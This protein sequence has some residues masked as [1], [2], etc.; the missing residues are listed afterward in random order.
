[1]PGTDETRSAFF[2][3]SFAPEDMRMARRIMYHLTTHGVRLWHDTGI[4]PAPAWETDTAK[5]IQ[6]CEAVIV[7]LSEAYVR[8]EACRAELSHAQALGKDC[9]LV[10]LDDVEL[11]VEPE[12]WHSAVDAIAAFFHETE[13]EFLRE[14]LR[15]EMIQQTLPSMPEPSMFPPIGIMPDDPLLPYGMPGIVHDDWIE[16]AECLTLGGTE[17]TDVTR[18]NGFHGY[19]SHIFR[20]TAKELSDQPIL[21]KQYSEQYA[22][23]LAVFADSELQQALMDLRHDNLSRIYRIVGEEKRHCLVME[24]IEGQTLAVVLRNEQLTA[25]GVF[26]YMKDILLGLEA[27]HTQKRPILYLDVSTLNVVIDGEKACMI[28][29]SEANFSGRP[30]PD[31]ARTHLT[32]WSPERLN[33]EIVDC[34]S[35]IY[36]SG[37]LLRQMAENTDWDADDA[38][39]AVLRCKQW[40]RRIIERATQPDRED[41]YQ[42]VQEMLAHVDEALKLLD[43]Q[44]PLRTPKARPGIDF[45]WPAGEFG[46]GTPFVPD[47]GPVG[48][49]GHLP[50]MEEDEDK[51]E[52]EDD[53]AFILRT[54]LEL[55]DKCET[56]EELRE[57]VRIILGDA[58][59]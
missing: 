23:E 26:R 13:E 9:V 30:Y 4:E 51:D 44:G 3:V 25:R 38:P 27:L 14:L 54:I 33:G 16:P 2:Y 1:M 58:E 6:E 5:H 43:D 46:P 36:E 48:M 22:E 28:D 56:L 39:E 53:A 12:K 47:D 15:M 11:P 21:I 52:M 40:A 32:D 29:F 10:F 57:S 42:T 55:V 24:E 19:A 34:R 18:V 41:R 31:T 17:Y 20:A 7:I 8:S 59:E 50:C 49:I 35:D 45:P 37:Q